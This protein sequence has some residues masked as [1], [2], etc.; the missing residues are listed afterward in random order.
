MTAW[1]LVLAGV[2]AGDGGMGMGAAREPVAV[3]FEG[4]WEGTLLRTGW[5]AP[6]PC[7]WDT[8][9]RLLRLKDYGA[10]T[11]RAEAG[12]AGAAAPASPGPGEQLVQ[13]VRFH[14]LDEM[15]VEARLLR[16][17]PILLLPPAGHRHQQQVSQ[18]GPPA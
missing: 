2:T 7:V 11:A 13:G 17:A 6:F 4:R 1:V 3:H 10:L 5:A 16:T 14:R 18:A 9:A 8:A 12:R 15:V